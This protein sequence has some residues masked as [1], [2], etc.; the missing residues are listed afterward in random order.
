MIAFG[1]RMY[2][3]PFQGRWSK[4]ASWYLPGRFHQPVHILPIYMLY[5]YYLIN[6]GMHSYS[7]QANQILF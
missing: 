2:H 4:S 3:P 6:N 5:K 7:R 1:E